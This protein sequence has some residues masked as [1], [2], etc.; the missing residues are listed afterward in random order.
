VRKVLLALLAVTGVL[1]VWETSQAM[2]VPILSTLDAAS[3]AQVLAEAEE[4]QGVCYGWEIAV[5]GES[6]DGIEQGSSRG[7]PGAVVDR[8]QCA[9]YA[10]LTGEITYTSALSESEDSARVGVDTNLGIDF[11]IGRFG[12]S[13]KD[14]LGDRDDA[15]LVGLVEALPLAVGEDTGIPFVEF[16]PRAEPLV[17]DGPTD[18]PGSDWW[19]NYWPLVLLMVAI[20]AA[21]VGGWLWIRADMT[22]KTRTWAST[23][24]KEDEE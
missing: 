15:T 7:G 16:E 18:R 21:L 22:T 9:R 8:D 10:V 13:I 5:T 14:L 23:I 1:M 4:V 3:L 17:G 11:S 24:D 19:R 20:P 6:S 12:L 2:A